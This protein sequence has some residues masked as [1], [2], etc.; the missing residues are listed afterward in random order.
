MKKK[1]IKIAVLLVLISLFSVFILKPVVETAWSTWMG[2]VSPSYQKHLREK[3]ESKSTDFLLGKM[4][5]PSV[6]YSGVATAL[7]RQRKE[8]S[9]VDEIL[10]LVKHG[11]FRRTKEL[12][13]GILY[14]WDEQQA[15]DLSMEILKSG[16]R[17]PLYEDALRNLSRR[18]Y[19]PAYPYVL[20][21]AKSDDPLATGAVKLLEDYGKPDAIP[22]LEAML[23][24]VRMQ[25]KL[26]AEIDRRRIYEAIESIK[27]QNNL[28]AKS[29]QG[30]SS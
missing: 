1:H 8:T 14:A 2:F 23:T 9:R 7:L 26:V 24:K 11:F 30:V 6:Y 3:W 12:A 17:H 20:D 27:K 4:R 22:I 29:P 28:I 13:L 19:E 25:D 15:I 10:W 21:L 18:K 5:H 16:K